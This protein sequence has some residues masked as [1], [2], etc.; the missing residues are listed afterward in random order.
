[1]NLFDL[2]AKITL[3]TSG[4]ESGLNSVKDKS[5]TAEANID[6]FAKTVNKTEKDLNSVGSVLDETA[7]ETGKVGDESSK[8]QRNI[9]NLTDAF[10]ESAKATNDASKETK[11]FIEEVEDAGKSTDS[12]EH[13]IDSLGNEF[14]DFSNDTRDA[15]KNVSIF[16]EILKAKLVSEGIKVAVDGLKKLGNA[17]VD[18]T[19]SSVDSYANY[20]QL[21]GG[22][23]TLFGGSAKLVQMYADNAYKTA[24]LSA[25]EY[26]ETVTSF[27]ASLLQSLHGNTA[28]A[29]NMADMAIKDM[30]DNANKMGTD[31]GSIK[32]AYQGFAK[33]N[34]SMLD[35]LKIGYGGTATEMFRLLQ[36]AADLNDEFAKTANFSID[37]KGHLEA[38]YADIVQAIHIV[39]NEM[40]ITGTTALE[41][42]HTISGSIASMKSAWENLLVGMADENADFDTLVNN[43][44]DSTLIAGENV[45]PRIGQALEG[46]GKLVEGL[47]PIIA[48]KLP[49][50]TEKI[51]PPIARA[52]LSVVVAFG[53]SI[54]ESAPMLLS[55]GTDIIQQ[56]SAGVS[57]GLPQFLETALP[58]LV[59]FSS[60]LR[61]NAGQL[62]DVGLDFLVNLAQG[63]ADGLPAFIENIPQIV[64]N[65][66]NIINDNAPKIIIAGV[67]IIAALIVGLIKAI[68]TL[69]ANIPQI[70]EAIF[71]TFQ[72]VNWWNIGSNIIKGI[73]QGLKNGASA[74]VDTAIEVAKAAFNAVKNFLGIRSPS[75]LFRDQ[76]GKMMALGLGEGFENNIPVSD[77]VESLGDAVEELED[78]EAPEIA[79]DLFDTTRSTQSFYVPDAVPALANTG[80]MG[81]NGGEEVFT[82]PREQTESPVR[83]L[84]VILE[85]DKMQLGRAVYRLNNE[86][87]QRVGLRLAGGVV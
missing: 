45:I 68:P 20:E 21:V 27:S 11:E 66:A 22:V 69:I 84:T 55:Y 18:V 56:V 79:P 52:A 17:V 42:E 70:I 44:V 60:S 87:V 6:D 16:S 25:N 13:G 31:M 78:F 59:E 83:D 29:A 9:E 35:N 63:I 37:N 73:G 74:L 82:V 38:G 67:K 50:L 10:E 53:Q 41:A 76:I 23:E 48:E 15:G 61:E 80:N 72:A 58:M 32:N 77:M 47:A 2:M 71:A 65:I 39:Q 46:V 4:Y 24:G 26:M 54:A 7:K 8:A 64:T 1:M 5:K 86:E 81:Y 19:K 62:I 43:F 51:I 40:G 33:Q 12:L 85:L 3:D 14:N 28:E 75:T 36:D 30:S 57:D 49:G 34:Y